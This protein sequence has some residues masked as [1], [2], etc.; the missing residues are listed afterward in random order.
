MILEN[1]KHR[2]L[3]Y[4]ESKGIAKSIF[5]E[6]TGIKRGLLDKD[7][8]DST[9]SDVFIAKI[10]ATYP[11]INPLWLITGEGEMLN[12]NE[13]FNVVQEASVEYGKRK[14]TYNHTEETLLYKLY[15]EKDAQVNEL[16]EKVGEQK[17]EIEMLK[18]KIENLNNE[19]TLMRSSSQFLPNVEFA[20][21]AR[22]KEK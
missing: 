6:K 16:S 1:T 22:V 19:I 7:K 2:I 12:Q 18:K 21:D 20:P 15:R 8:M 10:L 4:I 9:V 17:K 13:R 5:Y 14:E 3:Q 11:D